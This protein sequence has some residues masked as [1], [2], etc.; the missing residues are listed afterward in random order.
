MTLRGLFGFKDGGAPPVPID[1]VEPVSEIVK[2]FAT[3]AMSYGSISQEMH[4]ILAIAM[5]RSA[6]RSN[7]G[8]GGEDADRFTRDANGDSRRSAV[9]QVASGRFGVTSE[10]L[11]NADDIQIKMAQG[12]KPGEGGQLPG[13]QGLPVD[14]PDPA[15]HAGRR[16]DLA[17]AA[18]RHLL[19]RGPGAAH[20]RPEERQRAGARPR[21][22]RRR[23]GCRHGRGGG[24]K[25][26]ADVVL[27]S[28]HDGGTGASPLTSIK[29][30]GAPWELGLAET[31]QTLLLNG[32]R[33]R[34]VVQTDGQLKTGRDVV[35]AALLGA[36]EFGFATAPLV[37]SGCIMMRVCHLDTCP[38]GVAT[39]NPELRKKFNG[40]AEYVVDV[41]RVHRPG[42]AGATWRSSGS[43]A[44]TR[45]S[46]TPT[47]S[48]P[49]GRRPLEGRRARPVADPAR[50]RRARRRTALHQAWPRT[51][52]WTRRW[53]TR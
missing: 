26:H 39:Q 41:L 19:H 6:G 34:I 44:S 23:G 37:V 46:G 52:A 36:E 2:R 9:K 31:Q 28:G 50:A 30:A 11:V 3:G 51:T 10:Y 49:R 48:T 21:Q 29:H 32:L 25:A 53:T 42:G 24:C 33:D 12:A 8:E 1:E 27:I 20:P 15:L 18:P 43:A 5:N 40:K 13:S 17:A 7:T 38:V 4:E 16:P 14:R 47:C 45:R 22:A 35:I